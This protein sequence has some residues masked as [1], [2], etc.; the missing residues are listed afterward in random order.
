VRDGSDM[1]MC[2]NRANATLGDDLWSRNTLEKL[3]SIQHVL[4]RW[5]I[6][7]EKETRSLS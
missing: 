7:S 6:E 2:Y 1:V 4:E 5:F 3:K